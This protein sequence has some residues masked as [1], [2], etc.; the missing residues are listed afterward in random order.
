MS[1]H[2]NINCE[3]EAGHSLM[4]KMP[5]DRELD[6]VLLLLPP[7]GS[8]T[9]S[10]STDRT[11]CWCISWSRGGMPLKRSPKSSCIICGSDQCPTCLSQ[12][13]NILHRQSS[14][15]S[16]HAS[17][18]PQAG[19]NTSHMYVYI[20]MYVYTKVLQCITNC[21]SVC[22]HV[23]HASLED[24]ACCM[25]YVAFARSTEIL[26]HDVMQDAVST[27]YEK[28]YCDVHRTFNTTLQSQ[29]I[30]HL[31]SVSTTQKTWLL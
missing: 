9:M 29:G 15:M 8:G 18:L 2:I 6:L 10:I 25:V 16:H 27:K 26:H 17:C 24:S 12:S 23:S 21:V 3:T 20:C 4:F 14:A 31:W 13:T 22:K 1:A 19:V 11:P 5:A 7:S 28:Q 30:R